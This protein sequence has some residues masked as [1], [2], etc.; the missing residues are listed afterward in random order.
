MNMVPLLAAGDQNYAWFGL[1][2]VALITVA[3][4][5]NVSSLHTKDMNRKSGLA[6]NLLC[7]ACIIEVASWTVRSFGGGT[8]TGVFW[9]IIASVVLH[10]LSGAV[11]L[12][13]VWEHR[14]I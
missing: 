12:W 9:V 13:A 5:I 4:V 8:E 1:V 11:A 14:T 2:P 3:F 6:T 10:M 7:I